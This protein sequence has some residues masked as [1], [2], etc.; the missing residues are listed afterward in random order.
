MGYYASSIRHIHVSAMISES[1]FCFRIGSLGV[2]GKLSG[3]GNVGKSNSTDGQVNGGGDEE[4]QET[5]RTYHV[6]HSSTWSLANCRNNSRRIASV[7]AVASSGVLN[8]CFRLSW[9]GV[10]EGASEG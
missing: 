1:S 9:V 6:L 3:Y 8:A 5:S 10:S 2:M 4:G 7:A